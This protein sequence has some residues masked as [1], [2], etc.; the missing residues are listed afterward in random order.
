MKHR[1]PKAH[2]FDLVAG[3]TPRPQEYDLS[4]PGQLVGVPLLGQAPDKT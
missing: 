1:S 3:Q 2:I 4:V